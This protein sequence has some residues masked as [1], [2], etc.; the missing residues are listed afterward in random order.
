SQDRELHRLRGRACQVNVKQICNVLKNVFRTRVTSENQMPQTQFRRKEAGFTLVEIAIV[1]VIIGLL[2]GGILKGQEMITQARIK[3]LIN[4]FNGI[5]AAY[6]SYQDRYK[7]APG[8]DLSAATRWPVA[9]FPGMAAGDGNGALGGLYSDAP[10]GALVIPANESLAFWFHLRAAGFVAGATAGQA[11]W[12]QPNNSVGGIV[13]VQNNAFGAG[14]LVG[15]VLCSANVPD[16]IAGA[17]DTQVDDQRPN[18]GQLQA[19]VQTAV[20][21]ATAAATAPAAAYLEIGSTQL[22]MCKT[23]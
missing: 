16:K 12:T 5:T 15:L 3:N 17:V 1:L 13:G 8:D 9:T 23:I 19:G 4:D 18:G 20:N 10:P 11:A 22:V 7:S 2:L 6:F 21:Q 14:G